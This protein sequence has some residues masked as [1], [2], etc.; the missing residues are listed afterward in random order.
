MM[1]ITH[2][3]TLELIK[4]GL[5]K[6]DACQLPNNVGWQDVF[7]FSML[8]GVAAIVLDGV[9]RCFANGQD[10][11]IDFQTKMKWIGAVN[12]IEQ[13]YNQHKKVIRSL[14]QFYRQHGVSMMLMKGV[15]L[16]LD[17]PEP[18]HRPCGD[19]DIYLFGDLEKGDKLISEQYGIEIDYDHYKHTVFEFEG[20]KIENHYDFANHHKHRSSKKLDM[21]LKRCVEG[22]NRCKNVE[23]GDTDVYLPPAEFNA[24]FLI[25]HMASHFASEEVSLR[26]LLD[27][28]FFVE[29]HYNEVDW[30]WHWKICQEQ[31]MHQ[32][33]LAV[34]NI[35]VQHLGFEN[36]KFKTGGDTYL[37]EKVLAAFLN[38]NALPNYTHG[39]FSY[40][41]QRLKMWWENR[42]K[43]RLV[44][45]ESL[46]TT[47]FHQ[48]FAHLMKPS[49]LKG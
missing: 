17:Y 25:R 20:A 45:P 34:N 38:A 8:Q 12:H 46:A 36:S 32:F 7:T 2:G 27:W 19:I 15:G 3:A 33:L 37:T 26:Q 4:Y 43:H 49:T 9:D 18:N 29:K 30:N 10:I 11:S 41:I 6:S 35:C 5:R 16:S 44:Y 40:P 23:L 24:I 31:N 47:F 48:I 13:I 28:G 22:E 39:V 21:L 14:T 1:N 42:W